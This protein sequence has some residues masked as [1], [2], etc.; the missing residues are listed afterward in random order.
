VTA[1]RRHASHE[2]EKAR[3]HKRGGGRVPFSLDAA[4][5]ER[6]YALEPGGGE[7]PE[8]LFERRYAMEVLSRALARLAAH[9][10]GASPERAERFDALALLLWDD[11]PPQREVAERL[12]MSE[13]AL[14]VALHRLRA[15]LRDELRAEV[16][17]TVEDP[18]DLDEEIRALAAAL[19]SSTAGRAP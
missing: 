3:A 1:L 4:E 5:G 11:G 19:R 8:R 14:R 15:H 2:A 7:P 18:A 16:R 17:E 13:T 6:R 12:A 10:R 9:E